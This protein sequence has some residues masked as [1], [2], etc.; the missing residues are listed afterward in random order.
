M[1]HLQRVEAPAADEASALIGGIEICVKKSRLKKSWTP[2][3]AIFG[4]KMDQ[5]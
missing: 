4:E 1:F 2:R 3:I 5:N